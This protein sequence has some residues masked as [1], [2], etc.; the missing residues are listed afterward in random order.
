[1]KHKSG[2]IYCISDG[3]HVK[4]GR[5]HNPLQRL[6]IL[7]PGNPRPLTLVGVIP[8]RDQV[9]R[10]REIHL[11]YRGQHVFGEWFLPTEAMIRAFTK[12]KTP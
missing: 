11:K 5:S 4:I 12:R 3:E 9:K 6:S 1:M 2:F 8:T 7:Q 10:E